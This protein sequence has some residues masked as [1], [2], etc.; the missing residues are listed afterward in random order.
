[1]RRIKTVRNTQETNIK[2]TKINQMELLKL[3]NNQM[4]YGAY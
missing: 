3:S 4:A 1:M 2:K